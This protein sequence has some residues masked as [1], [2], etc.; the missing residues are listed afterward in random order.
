[1]LAS[2]YYLEAE[3]GAP[4]A[5]SRRLAGHRPGAAVVSRVSPE[6]TPAPFPFAKAARSAM[7]VACLGCSRRGR[8]DSGPRPAS[9][10]STGNVAGQQ[11]C[12]LKGVPEGPPGEDCRMGA[13]YGADRG[14]LVGP[15][16][17]G[18]GRSERHSRRA[19]AVEQPVE[20]RGELAPVQNSANATPP[21]FR[22]VMSWSVACRRWVADEIRMARK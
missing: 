1:M 19:E 20:V 4:P 8:Y 5:W 14:A 12:E 21:A 3:A 7:P 18:R 13:S 22:Q 17:V 16:G 9:G 15:V 11:G 10:T 6:P 2:T